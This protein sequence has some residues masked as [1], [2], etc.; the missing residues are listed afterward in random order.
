M[1]RL[2][3]IPSQHALGHPELERLRCDGEL[4]VVSTS[5]KGAGGLDYSRG[6]LHLIGLRGLKFAESSPQISRGSFN[7]VECF[8]RL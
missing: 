6:P 8:K 1:S 3:Q 2:I 5:A 4:E 7:I